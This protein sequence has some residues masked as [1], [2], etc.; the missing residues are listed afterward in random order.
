MLGFKPFPLDRRTED[1]LPQHVKGAARWHEEDDEE[2]YWV[3]DLLSQEYRAIEYNENTKQWYFVG[4]DTR[5]G[6]WIATGTVL[7]SFNLGRQSIR[8][9]SKVSTIL[10]DN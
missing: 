2:G 10:V 6:H 3:Y 5:T 4:Q 7:S 1:D 8:P 9:I